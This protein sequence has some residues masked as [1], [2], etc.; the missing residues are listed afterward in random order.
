[1]RR[2]ALKEGATAMTRTT[3]QR[4]PIK[5]SRLNAVIL[6]VFGLTRSRSCVDVDEETL[7]VRMSWAF[8][9]DIP[10]RLIVRVARG[11]DVRFTAG[12]HITRRGWL[13]NGAGTGIVAVDL[14]APVRGRS[15]IPISFRRV[16]IS[17]ED[18]DG[19]IAAVSPTPN[20]AG[21]ASS[22]TGQTTGA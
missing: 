5:C 4:F 21:A 19:F 2:S 9:A 11:P 16:S 3:A 22:A 15:V 14:T 17:L 6:G 8:Q 12:A 1:V 18:P 10:R 7:R 20:P 13:V